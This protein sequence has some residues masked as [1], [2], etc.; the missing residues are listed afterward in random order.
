MIRNEW[1]LELYYQSTNDASFDTKEHCIMTKPVRIPSLQLLPNKRTLVVTILLAIVMCCLPGMSTTAFAATWN[2][3]SETDLD[4]AILNA[5]SGDTIT[6]SGSFTITTPKTLGPGLAIT[7]DLNGQTITASV[8]SGVDP[9]VV[10]GLGASLTVIDSTGG[11]TV[12]SSGQ[13]VFRLQQG[14]LDLKAGTFTTTGAATVR[15]NGSTNLPDANFSVLTVEGSTVLES[16]VYGIAVLAPTPP[17][18][19]YGAVVNVK[20]NASINVGV[21]GMFINGAILGTGATAPTFNIMGGTSSSIY[22]AGYANW[23]ISGGTINGTPSSAATPP[24]VTAFEMA[25]GTLNMTGG[26]INAFGPANP[27]AGT[28]PAPAAS[29]SV[30][31]GYGIAFV[32]RSGYA[33]ATDPLTINI[34]GGTINAPDGVALGSLDTASGATTAVPVVSVTGGEFT[35]PIV[36]NPGPG[37][38]P[39]SGFISGGVFMPNGPDPSLIVEGSEAVE[40]DD[41]VFIIGTP[42][43]LTF[44][45]AG[46]TLTP[47]TSA[48]K[49]DAT[50][51]LWKQPL[52]AGTVFSMLPVP[53]KTGYT[54]VQWLRDDGQALTAPITGDTLYTAQWQLVPPKIPSTGDATGAALTG[55]TILIMMGVLL[56][57]L[58]RKARV[59]DPH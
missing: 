50:T 19:A 21:S 35:G 9:I 25:A 52:A 39:I 45:P 41:G 31:S 27:A 7:L 11:G 48:M 36:A 23:N 32:T 20:D 30:T 15:V 55:M 2:V 1:L 57:L 54:F 5:S 44:D 17:P 3:S 24:D 33:S 6:L 38:V 37:G 53:T 13:S 4:N 18:F 42:V 28:N 26:T 46:G 51:G 43:T 10:N 22:A 56:I 14:A 58:S 8:A 29:G 16:A 59:K 47:T 40:I 12:A 49:Q 34:S